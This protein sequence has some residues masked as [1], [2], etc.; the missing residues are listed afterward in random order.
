MAAARCKWPLS[1]GRVKLW[2]RASY[3]LRRL[4]H[5]IYGQITFV[6]S[7]QLYLWSNEQGEPTVRATSHTRLRARDHSL[8]A[9]P[10]VENGGVG[11]SS[12]HT[13]LEGPKEGVC[14][15]KVDVKVYIDSYMH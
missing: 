10:L 7:Q 11:P 15:C 6:Y 4:Q 2:S 14:E 13:V 5:I 12:L 3:R 9:L 1:G 8:Q